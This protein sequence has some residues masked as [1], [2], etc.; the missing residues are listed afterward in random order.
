[1]KFLFCFDSGIQIL[2]VL[3]PALGAPSTE[4]G[5]SGTF[6]PE[7]NEVSDQDSTPSAAQKR[8]Y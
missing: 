6:I 3:F 1:L 7:W 2:T 5:G 8:W 4:N